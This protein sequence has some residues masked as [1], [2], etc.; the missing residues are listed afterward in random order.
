MDS[1]FDQKRLLYK[2][3][4]DYY[5]NQ[6]TQ[7]EIAKRFGLSRIKVS[8]LLRVARENNIVTITLNAP[9]SLTAKREE[10]LEQKYGLEE[11]RIVF[12]EDSVDQKHIVKELAPAAAEVLLRRINPQCTVGVTWGN[13]ILA[14]VEALPLTP[15]PGLMIVQLNGD[16]SPIVRLEN[17][18]ELSRQLAQ[19]LFAELHLLSAPG[20]AKTKEAASFFKNDTLIEET[21]ALAAKADVAVLGIGMLEKNSKLLLQNGL[22]SHAD[23]QEMA[24]NKAVG[25]IALRYIN[26]QGKPVKLSLDERVVGLTFKELV[27]IP[28]VIAVAGGDEKHEVIRA[29][30]QSKMLNVLITD[31]LTAEYLLK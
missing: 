29:A 5:D 17:S 11:A 31:H 7:N 19:K 2:I 10:A 26:A 24:K 16:L 3:A 6:L 25:D 1:L 18:A 30:L 23:I 14:L 22:L 8:R 28:C 21:L 12:C 27:D 20:L 9:D 4:R 13:T 15:M